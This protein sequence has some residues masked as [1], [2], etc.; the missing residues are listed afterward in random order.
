MIRL[1]TCIKFHQ[2]IHLKDLY[3]SLYVKFTSILRLKEKT[4]GMFSVS[5]ANRQKRL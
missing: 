5:K 4:G 3:I 1:Y 2:T